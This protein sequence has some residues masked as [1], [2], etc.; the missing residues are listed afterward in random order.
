MPN[1]L[2]DKKYLTK[3]FEIYNSTV[4]GVIVKDTLETLDTKVDK[5][6]G[7]KLSKNDFTDE[8]KAKLEGLGEYNDTKLF[9]D[10]G[11][12]ADMIA[13]LK[14]DE[15]TEGSVLHYVK[16]RV[17]QILAE[18][19]EQFDTIREISEWIDNHTNK[20]ANMK[21][22]IDKNTEDIMAFK[23]RWENYGVLVGEDEDLDFVTDDEFCRYEWVHV[24]PNSIK[25]VGEGS[26][27]DN[28]SDYI[29]GLISSK[30]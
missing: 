2:L 21:L 4:F 12:N 9:E 22:A 5:R 20:A 29:V 1:R 8:L 17:A 27:T 25:F 28:P 15:E 6:D 23:E 18:A 19:P 13:V 10:I 3:Q 14:G 11:I 16:T 24:V 30:L 26:L 7:F